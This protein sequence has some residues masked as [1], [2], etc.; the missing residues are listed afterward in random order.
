VLFATGSV[1]GFGIPTIATPIENQKEILYGRC[2]CL[3]ALPQILL[4]K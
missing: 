2:L 1:P 4:I 3:N